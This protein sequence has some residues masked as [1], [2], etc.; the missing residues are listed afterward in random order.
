MDR[1]SDRELAEASRQF[2]AR[3]ARE[4]KER[5]TSGPRS[6]RQMLSM[7]APSLPGIAY[8]TLTQHDLFNLYQLMASS[9]ANVT[10][11]YTRTYIM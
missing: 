11:A 8:H 9:D 7:S 10:F 6:L 4:L 2:E 5:A 1:Q 3:F